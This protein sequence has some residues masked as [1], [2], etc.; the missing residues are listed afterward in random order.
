LVSA[1]T[2]INFVVPDVS[3]DALPIFVVID[4]F[5]SPFGA[6]VAIR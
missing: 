1:L 6:F 3:G 5:S 4:G 2:Q